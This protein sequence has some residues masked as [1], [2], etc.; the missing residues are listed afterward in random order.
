MKKN[1]ETYYF[2]YTDKIYYIKLTEKEMKELNLPTYPEFINDEQFETLKKYL[3][4][5]T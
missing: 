1:K 4:R 3:K 2:N 5:V